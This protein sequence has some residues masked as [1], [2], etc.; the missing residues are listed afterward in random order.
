MCAKVWLTNPIGNFASEL[1]GRRVNKPMEYC[2][3]QQ[4]GYQAQ[5]CLTQVVP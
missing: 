1:I 4:E 2:D 5:N 3:A